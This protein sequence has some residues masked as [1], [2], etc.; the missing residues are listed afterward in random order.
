MMIP[1]F[2]FLSFAFYVSRPFTRTKRQTSTFIES[3]YSREASVPAS[4][5]FFNCLINIST[6]CDE[7]ERAC[8]LRREKDTLVSRAR[9]TPGVSVMPPDVGSSDVGSSSPNGKL[10][11]SYTA[12]KD[13]ERLDFAKSGLQSEA[14]QGN[15]GVVLE[16]LLKL[17]SKV[18]P[19]D[20]PAVYKRALLRFHPDR[21]VGKP[22]GKRASYEER[23][24]H[25]III[26]IIV[27]SFFR[28]A[29]RAFFSSFPVSRLSCFA[30]KDR[31][32]GD[33]VR[34]F[35]RRR[36]RAFEILKARVDHIC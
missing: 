5:S 32:G 29:K 19:R 28:P 3:S 34:S 24:A 18:D 17:D 15:I 8:A 30:S 35:E 31:D 7:K 21:H 4:G 33:R 36:Q 6:L 22:L 10:E 13:R 2:A 9:G 26:I 11:R 14:A 27:S 20:V 16:R 1:T 25:I 23:C 12:A